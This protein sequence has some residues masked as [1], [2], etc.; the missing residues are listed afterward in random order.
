M[1]ETNL[2]KEYGHARA[3]Y[4][5]SYVAL[6]VSKSIE[7]GLLEGTPIADAVVA[8]ANEIVAA[9]ARLMGWGALT[10]EE[11]KHGLAA[12]EAVNG[13]VTPTSRGMAAAELGRIMQGVGRG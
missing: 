5:A 12:I 6:A 2:A 11:I 10:E 4:I 9:G 3:A 7:R 1:R 13:E 8:E